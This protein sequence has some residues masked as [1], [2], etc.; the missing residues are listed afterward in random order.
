M[1]FEEIVEKRFSVRKFKDQI[2]E[3]DKLLKVLNAARMA[4]SA[5]NYQ[6]WHFIVVTEKEILNQLYSVYK[7]NWIQEAP[8]VIVACADHSTSWKRSFDGK[9]FADVDVAIAV[10]HMTL[11]ATN[12]GLGTCW[13]CSFD[14]AECARILRLPS[15]IEPIALLPLGYPDISVPEKKRKALS[16]IVHLNEFGKSFS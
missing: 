2:V 11:M 6:P 7:R 1:N 9:D 5:V 8:L 13:V 14:A 3:K 12:L 16:E 10:E 15:S 4:P